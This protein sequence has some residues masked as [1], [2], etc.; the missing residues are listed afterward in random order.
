MRAFEAAGRRRSFTL[1][2]KE[3]GVSQVAISRQV[4]ILEEWLGVK[5]FIRGTRE[6]RLTAQGERML[7]SVGAALD[8]LSQAAA[9]VSRRGRRNVLAI[10]A[11]TTF[12]QRWL[13]PRLARFHERHPG[14]EVRLTT[15]VESVD[16]ARQDLDAA[17]RS[18]DGSG[19][20]GLEADFLTP[21]TLLPVA[22]PALLGERHGALPVEHL[23]RMTLLHSLARPD[24]WQTWLHATGA[25]RIIDSRKGLKFE[26]SALAYEAALQGGG[27]AMGVEALVGGYLSSG[28][29]VSPF[30][31]R[32]R[33]PGGYYL[34]RPLNKPPTTAMRAFRTWLLE[35][36]ADTGVAT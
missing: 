18:G 13:V 19:W 36:L 29:L 26:S 28:M 24:D 9:Q 6:V 30:G 20:P 23:A 4:K 11:Y 10:Q 7:S 31:P 3:L 35:M 33:L 34:V 2:G 16:F 32:V 12:A 15:S 22:T 17:V 14:I 27:I 5:L 1:A 21:I 8:M 25:D